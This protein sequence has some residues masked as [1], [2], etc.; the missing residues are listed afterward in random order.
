VK[1]NPQ[2][3]QARI[4][5]S[6]ALLDTQSKGVRDHI[7]VVQQVLAMAPQVADDLKD[8]LDDGQK[9]RPDWAALAKVRT[10]LEL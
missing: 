2:D 3:P 9:R 10:W 1:L 6:L 7:Q 8:S 5:L 4:N